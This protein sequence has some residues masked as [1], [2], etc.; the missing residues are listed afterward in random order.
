M[1][2]DSYLLDGS[3]GLRGEFPLLHVLEDARSVAVKPSGQGRA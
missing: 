1:I 3:G 2:N